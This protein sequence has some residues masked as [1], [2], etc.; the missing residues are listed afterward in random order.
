MAGPE[1]LTGGQVADLLGLPSAEALRRRLPRLQ[2]ETDFPPPMPHVLRGRL[3]RA[4]QVRLWIARHG[5][6]EPAVP[7]LEN[8]VPMPRRAG[9]A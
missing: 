9:A 3:W 2:R 1:F 7:S 6:P 4:D 5:A 8:V